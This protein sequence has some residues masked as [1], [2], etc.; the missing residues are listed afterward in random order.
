MSILRKASAGLLCTAMTLSLASCSLGGADTTYGAI[1]D[2]HKIPAGVFISMQMNAYSEAKNYTDAS[3][4][5]EEA[6]TTTASADAATTEATTTTPF[7][8]KVI[9]GKSVRDW[10]NDEATVEMQ[11]YVAIENKFDELGLGFAENEPEKVNIYI[12][13]LW[14]YYGTMY[15]EMGISQDSLNLVTLNS[16]KKELI[17]NHIYGADGEKAVSEADVKKYLSDNNFRINYIEI[18]LKDG[19][20]NLLKS[21]GKEE[22]NAKAEEYIERAKNGEDFNA[23]LK[24]YNDSLN[25][26]T[27]STDDTTAVETPIAEAPDNTMIVTKEGTFPDANI[28]TKLF[29][30]S[31]AAGD[32][33]IVES[34]NSEK[35]YVVQCLDLFADETYYTD[36]E[37]Y[38]RHQLKDEEFEAEIESW[39]VGQTVERNEAAY[40]RYKY[41]K[42]E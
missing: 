23:I 37:S 42:F 5:A 16:E 12:E 6:V 19:E 29:D 35:L 24:E 14:E 21:E 22:M 32:Y 30:G 8:D 33:F 25:T 38:V 17:F 2:G 39:I 7:S 11:K 9:E 26:S 40:K 36:N 31:V 4:A 27:A 1:I 10:I 41:E 13:S 20:G 34:A 18:E 28:V 3:S 15:E